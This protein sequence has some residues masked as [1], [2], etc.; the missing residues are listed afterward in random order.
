MGLPLSCD[1]TQPLGAL[2]FVHRIERP[3]GNSL[4]ASAGLAMGASV[5]TR[6]TGPGGAEVSPTQR[7]ASCRAARWTLY[8]IHHTIRMTAIAFYPRADGINLVH[9]CNFHLE[10]DPL[11]Y[12]ATYQDKSHASSQVDNIAS[13]QLTKNWERNVRLR[14]QQERHICDA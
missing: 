4:A 7:S 8:L 3:S 5:D 12:R 13:R 2:R 1:R 9:R 6:A 10:P 14:Q 11:L